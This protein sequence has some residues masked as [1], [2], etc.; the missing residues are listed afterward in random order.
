MKNSQKADAGLPAAANLR[1]EAEQRLRHKKAPSVEAMAQADVHA[2]VHELQVHQ[3][4]L[5]AVNRGLEAEIA[6]RKQAEEALA[7]EQ[8]NLQAVFDVV[9]V[10]ML[11]ID[12]DGVVTRVND[13]VSRWLGR[14]LSACGDKQPG[15]LIGC[16]H[17]LTDPAGCGRTPHCNICPIRNAFQSVLRSAQ[18]VRDVETEAVLSVGGSEVRLCLEVSADPLFLDGKRHAI[19]AMNN[20]TS[21]KQAEEAL[22]QIAAELVRS[23][24]DLEQFASVA[25]H[26]LQ[27]P[28]RT[29][30]GFV[31]LLR[32]KYGNRLDA[33]ADQFIDFA[34][35]GAK[36]M[37]TLINDL[38]AYSRV[39]TRGRELT[40]TDA[41]A[42]LRQALGNLDASIQETGAE[43][44][45]GEMPTV[46]AD[47]TQ[48][49]QLFQNLIGNALKFRGEAPPKI[50][51]D[52]CR[53]GDHWLFSVRDNGIGIKPEFQYR[54]FLIFQRLHTRRQY[55]GTGIGLTICKKIA[56]RHGGRIWVQSQPGEGATFY[57]TLPT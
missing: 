13:T 44:T 55:A 42:A 27:E 12:E 5:V 23:N 39:G 18:P 38:L 21:R 35:D 36:Q 32:Q 16:V 49:V 46:R 6:A 14:D 53:D 37:Q 31:E 54:I 52:A 45:R 10:A 2:L 19:V 4:E 50:H 33:E 1:H 20:I 24:E 22:R 41:G 11:V 9:N 47:H 34:V 3:D 40:P 48:L 57:F 28:L 56:D 43:I 29:V 25:S 17:A 15:D 51:V 7:K 26:D 30:T 8:A